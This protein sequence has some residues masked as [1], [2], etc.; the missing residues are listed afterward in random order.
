V[1]T[2]FGGDKLYDVAAE[3]R[4]YFL[5]SEVAV[6]YVGAMVGPAWIRVDGDSDPA[7]KTAAFGGFKYYV[8][9]R[10]SIFV[11]AQMGLILGGPDASFGAMALGV[12]AKL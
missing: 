9:P 6:P 4:Y 12:S 11:E 10:I 2:G 3:G 1:E 5:H 7:M 8:D